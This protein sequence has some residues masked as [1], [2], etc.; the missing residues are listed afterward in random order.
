[1]TALDMPKIDADSPFSR[2][3][4]PYCVNNTLLI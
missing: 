3:R 2:E 1:M 4:G